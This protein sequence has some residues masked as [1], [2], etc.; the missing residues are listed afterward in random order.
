MIQMSNLNLIFIEC[1]T[2]TDYSARKVLT[3][4][5]K[6]GQWLGHVFELLKL[7][8]AYGNIREIRLGSPW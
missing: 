1:Q 2:L 8:N 5:F 3:T 4:M 6:G 7:T